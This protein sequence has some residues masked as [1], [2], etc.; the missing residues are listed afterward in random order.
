MT[1]CDNPLPFLAIRPPES[2]P[3]LPEVLEREVFETAARLYPDYTQNLVPVARR[4]REWQVYWR[5]IHRNTVYSYI[6][7]G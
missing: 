4:V 5:L 2:F 7:R 3:N 6:Y 1:P